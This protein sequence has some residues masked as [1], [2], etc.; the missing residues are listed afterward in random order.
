LKRS[1]YYLDTDILQLEL[2]QELFGETYNVQTQRM[3][4][5][6]GRI[7]ADHPADIIISSD[8]SMPE[9]DGL[10]FLRDAAR[11]CPQSVRIM[12][13][14][15][16]QLGSLF[17]EVS[18]GIINIFVPKP[19]TEE[20]MRQVLERARLILDSPKRLQPVA[21]ERRIAPRHKIRIE[22]RV[23]L[24]A[25]REAKSDSEDVLLLTSY[26]YDISDSGLALII[27]EKDMMAL[28]D[29]AQTYKLRLMLT[30][31][32]GPMELTV[33]PVRTQRFGEVEQREYLIGTQITDMSGRDRVLF[34]Q[35]IRDLAL[36]S[37]S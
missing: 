28:S 9:S 23:L 19:W 29:Y 17:N 18:A 6:P 25:I 31:P 12:M 30:L 32:T 34:M 33:T 8:Q 37:P 5:E 2:F 13:S 35:Y 4:D 11:L 26:T 1:I 15:H 27:T 20:Q 3:T 16:V 14:R 24:M 10:E 21:D 7:L 22:T 36:R